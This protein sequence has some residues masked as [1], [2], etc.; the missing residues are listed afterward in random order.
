MV[1]NPFGKPGDKKLCLF[2]AV[3]KH[4]K[5]WLYSWMNN[6]E[7]RDKYK[8]S[9]R[10][11]FEWLASKSILECSSPTI[12]RN[13]SEWVVQKILPFVEKTLLLS[14]LFL[15]AYNEYTNS[16][17]EIKVSCL[18]AGQTVAPFMRIAQTTKNTLERVDLKVHRKRAS[19]I[20]KLISMPLWTT[21]ASSTDVTRHAEGI[22]QQQY[23]LAT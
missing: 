21:S 19:A 18:K 17:A 6:V 13:M 22:L 5:N 3:K 1:S 2:M 14:R 7:T 9:K 16:V 20:Q 8:T 12:Q 15:R 11:L 4:L 10:M 23:L